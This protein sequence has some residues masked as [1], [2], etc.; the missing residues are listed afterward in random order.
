[1]PRARLPGAQPTMRRAAWNAPATRRRSRCRLHPPRSCAR[2]CSTR[3]RSRAGS[4]ASTRPTSRRSTSRARAPTRCRRASSVSRC[5]SRPGAA[6]YIPLDHRYTGVPQ[7][8]DRART[9]ARLAPWLA[10]PSKKKLGHNVKYDEHAL[11]NEGLALGGVAHDTLLQSYV[12]E[13]HKPHDMDNL[14]WRHLNV[15]T[16]TLRRRDRQGRQSHPVRAG[17]RRARNGIRGRGCGRHAAPARRA[18]S[19]DRRR[20]QARVHLRQRRAARARRAV[21]HGAQRHPH[22]CRD[23]GEAGQGARRAR[24]GARAAGARARG[25]AVQPGLAEADLRDPVHADEASRAEEDG[26]RSA[27]DRRGRAAAARRRLSAAQGPARA[28]RARE[29]QVDVHR[30]AAADGQREHGARAHHVRASR[31]GDGSPRRRTIRTCRTSRC[32]RRKAGASARRS[33]RRRDT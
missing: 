15:K 14:A 17:R 26:D 33:S 3:T 19:C 1:M 4:T 8:L 9:L 13:S 22:R 20:R 6:R 2:R 18:P 24:D 30:Q 10:D 21:P 5:R 31:R 16:I 11:A 28:S 12:L 29:A 7:Q 27:V 32:A 25:R 23:A